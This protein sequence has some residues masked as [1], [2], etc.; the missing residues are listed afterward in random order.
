MSFKDELLTIVDQKLNECPEKSI[1]DAFKQY[2]IQTLSGTQ[3]EVCSPIVYYFNTPLADKDIRCIRMLLTR[4]L[5][6]VR[7]FVTTTAILL[8]PM[9]LLPGLERTAQPF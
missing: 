2:A 4:E 6:N 7:F 9:E 5:P 3:D 8:D 1:V